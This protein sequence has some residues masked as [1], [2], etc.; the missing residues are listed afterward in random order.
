MRDRQGDVT[1]YNSNQNFTPKNYLNK[2]NQFQMF[3]NGK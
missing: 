1:R 2:L 3:K